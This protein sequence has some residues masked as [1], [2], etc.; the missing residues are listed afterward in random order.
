MCSLW[1]YVFINPNF[2]FVLF[3]TTELMCVADLKQYATNKLRNKRKHFEHLIWLL[4]KMHVLNC[5]SNAICLSQLFLSSVVLH[6]P[7]RAPMQTAERNTKLMRLSYAVC[8][9]WK[10]IRAP[11][12]KGKQRSFF[13]RFSRSPNTDFFL[14]PPFPF[15]VATIITQRFLFRHFFHLTWILIL[16]NNKRKKKNPVFWINF[17]E[18][19]MKDEQNEKKSQQTNHTFTNKIKTFRNISTVLSFRW[20][21][22]NAYFQF[23]A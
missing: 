12:Y 5:M 9:L 21:L 8:V 18:I 15:G 20:T 2:R 17:R 22:E 23:D 16:I 7:M 3:W 4:E 6:S 19:E 14:I 10:L 13:I 1:L 11:I